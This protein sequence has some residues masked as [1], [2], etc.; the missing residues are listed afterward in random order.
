V[1]DQAVTILEYE[2]DKTIIFSPSAIFKFLITNNISAIG[3]MSDNYITICTVQEVDNAKELSDKLVNWLKKNQIIENEQSNCVLGMKDLGYKPGKRHVEAIG[4]DENILRLQVCGM[5]VKTEREVFNAMAFTALTEMICPKCE[6]NR[7]EG[8]TPEDFYTDNLTS[9]QLETFHAVFD[10]FNNWTKKEVSKLIC[11]YCAEP[12]D[13]ESYKIGD[14][15]ALSNLGFT[16]WNWPQLT[17]EFIEQVK[18]VLGKD[19]K[20]INGHI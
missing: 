3:N 8:I 4:F 14:T 16:F 18:A 11:P 10:E 13:L 20:V 6:R 7:F 2:K 15:I 5:E 19:V 12:S 9:E 1:K 17:P